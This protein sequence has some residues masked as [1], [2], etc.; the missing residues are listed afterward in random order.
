MNTVKRVYDL[1][2]ERSITLYQLSQVSG[3]SYST[4]KTTEKRGGQLKVDTIERICEALGIT[5]SEFS[6]KRHPPR[7]Q[8]CIS[9]TVLQ[10]DD[11]IT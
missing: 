7:A 3:V 4:V 11:V 1:I 10:R 5:M 8:R 9:P 2:E 6:K